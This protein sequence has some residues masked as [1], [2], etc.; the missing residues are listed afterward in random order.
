VEFTRSASW[1]YSFGFEGGG[2][3]SKALVVGSSI[4]LEMGHVL[5]GD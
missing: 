1:S 5:G 4:D 3:R 2:L